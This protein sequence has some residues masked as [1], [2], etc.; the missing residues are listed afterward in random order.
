VAFA[1]AV[2]VLIAD[3]Q[4][5]HALGT[6]AK[7]FVAEERG[8]RPAAERLRSAVMPLLGSPRSPADQR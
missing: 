4:R 5:R 3:P 7:R 8:L 6:A 2:E 1:A